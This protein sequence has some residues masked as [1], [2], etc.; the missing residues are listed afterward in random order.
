[1]L[2]IKDVERLKE[3]LKKDFTMN[4]ELVYVA[5]SLALKFA[6]FLALANTALITTKHI[7]FEGPRRETAS[8]ER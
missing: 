1:M 4:K 7:D 2:N 8:P 3:D 5:G 6:L